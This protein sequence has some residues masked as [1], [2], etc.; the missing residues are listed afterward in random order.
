MSV[1]QEISSRSKRSAVDD[2]R[3]TPRFQLTYPVALSRHGETFG[4]VTKT[5]NVSCR[6]F[7]CFSERPF[8][9]GERLDCEMAIPD[10]RPSRFQSND[11]VLH[12]V[13]EVLRVMSRGIG[14]GFGLACR[15]ERYTIGPKARKTLA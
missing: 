2:Q 15:L 5:E 13:V 12:G 4:V 6:G 1:V 11:L 14:K 8:W 10:A 9:P 3:S 7:C